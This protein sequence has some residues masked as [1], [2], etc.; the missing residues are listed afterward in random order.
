MSKRSSKIP[1]SRV[2]WKRNTKFGQ[3][4]INVDV[5]QFI[6][7]EPTK[8]P[9]I[10]Q[11][12]KDILKK[13]KELAGKEDL[14]RSKFET[15]QEATKWIN[16]VFQTEKNWLKSKYPKK[17]RWSTPV[18]FFNIHSLQN[19]MMPEYLGVRK[20]N[21]KEL[22]EQG[23]SK[24]EYVNEL[25]SLMGDLSVK[26]EEEEED[27]SDLSLIEE[28]D[29]DDELSLIED[30]D[31]DVELTV[32]KGDETIHQKAYSDDD[33]ASHISLN[34]SDIELGDSDEDLGE[35]TSNFYRDPMTGEHIDPTMLKVRY[36]LTDDELEEWGRGDTDVNRRGNPYW[37]VPEV[38]I[39]KK[40]DKMREMR[41]I[42][43]ERYLRDRWSNEGDGVIIV[44]GVPIDDVIEAKMKELFGDSG[45]KGG[46]RRRKQRKTK[47]IG[48]KSKK[49][50]KM[51][52][53][54][55]KKRKSMKKRTRKRR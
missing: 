53:R 6:I 21:K 40:E 5:E 48:K 17:S 3:R 34:S 44:D 31:D 49:H 29:D 45:K 14:D 15:P 27:T 12:N 9:N 1:A 28:S 30:S 46:R 13:A 35:I 33:A 24:E 18:Y 22:S 16:L 50:K 36:E 19:R 42:R 20:A 54:K 2:A 38:V 55:T 4:M 26:K 47:R 10:S 41:K 11:W 52:K 25:S 23:A 7:V 32:V 43:L 37:S 51:G 39:I 8:R